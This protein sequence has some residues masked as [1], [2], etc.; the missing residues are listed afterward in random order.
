VFKDLRVGL[1]TGQMRPGEKAATM[2]SF[3]DGS[4]D[5]LVATTV[6]EVGVDVSNATVMIIEDA[7]R[8][9]LAQLHQLR[10]RVGRGGHG[11]QVL[12]FADP[13]TEDGRRRMKAITSTADG[14]DLAEQDL[15]LRGEGQML[16]ERQHGLPE[17]RLASIVRDA[18]LVE[19][20][21]ESAHDIVTADPHLTDPRHAPLMVAVRRTYGRDWE[22]VSSG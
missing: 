15:R 16:G 4:L 9:G 20:A 12:L 8:F 3:V 18:D 6:V 10:G 19:A 21:R 1:L 22:W 14:F 17:L 13:R 2:E 5:V 7:D 11:G